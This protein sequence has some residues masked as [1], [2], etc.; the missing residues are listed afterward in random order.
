VSTRQN[1]KFALIVIVAL[2]GPTSVQAM[3]PVKGTPIPPPDKIAAQFGTLIDRY[4]SERSGYACYAEE[5]EQDSA[6]CFLALRCSFSVVS[7]RKDAIQGFGVN[8]GG[9]YFLSDYQC[10]TKYFFS[11]IETMLEVLS[12]LSATRAREIINTMDGDSK[13]YGR[14]DPNKLGELAEG[15]GGMTY[16]RD[17]E[18]YGPDFIEGRRILKIFCWFAK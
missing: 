8:F 14:C 11:Q 2:I 10:N 4:K 7:Y 17:E 9:D 1:L 12:G 3:F 6:N 13:N 16:A 18:M 15:S 5:G